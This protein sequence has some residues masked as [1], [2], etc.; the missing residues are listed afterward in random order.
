MKICFLG[1]AV[2]HHLRR[3]AKYFA[4][5]GH[6]VHI[7][8][9]NPNTLDNYGQI[10]VHIARKCFPGAMLIS[11]ALSLI[12]LLFNV[13][14]LIKNIKP[15]ILHSHS[16]SGYAWITMLSGFH[17]FV[18]TPWGTDIL[19]S[20]KISKIDRMLTKRASQKADLIH[21]DG[22]NLK[23]AMVNIGISQQKIIILTFGVD[24]QR[25]KPNSKKEDLKNRFNLSKSK[26]VIST[27]TLNPVHNVETFIKS[28]PIVLESMP[29][30]R[31]III[32]H[33]P[34]QE[35]LIKLSQSLN[36]YNAI[37]FLGKVEEGEMII[38][39]QASDVYVS[40]SLSE[41][42]LASSTAEAMACELP[43]INTDTGDIDLWIKDGEG[44]F[45]IPT[46]NPEKLAEKI[47]YLFKHENERMKFGKV[48]RK[49]IEERNNYYKEMAKMENIYK[50]LIKDKL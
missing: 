28:I 24:I 35:Y 37:R 13:K 10:K 49:V 42:G 21:C 5:N 44:G 12:P 40:T 25:F 23:R 30:T 11:R 8:T 38:C 17:P 31:F 9:F 1:D 7:I 19:I 2:S 15:D 48:N 14:S 6:E 39:L 46:K 20:I 29:D 22:E 32:G 36:I 26:V 47:V 41:S 43:V 33:G 45:I 34:E 18:I 3:W 16:A 27:R 50:K 4:N